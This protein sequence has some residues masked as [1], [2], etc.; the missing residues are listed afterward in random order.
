VGQKLERVREMGDRLDHRGAVKR[1]ASRRIPERHG[2]LPYAGLGEVVREQLGL[3]ADRLRK[4]LL[5]HRRDPAMKLL[6]PAFEQALIR[7][8]L[9]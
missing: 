3:S 4:L 1:Q 6:P 9:D 8:V 7:G 2:L 5:Q